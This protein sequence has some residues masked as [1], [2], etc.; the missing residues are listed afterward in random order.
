LESHGDGLELEFSSSWGDGRLESP[1]LGDF[2]ADNLLLAL[3][4]LLAWGMPVA[5]AMRRLRNVTAVTGRM[6]SLGGDERPR[7]VVDYA[8]TPDALE[9]S[10]LA[11]RPHTTGRL[12]LVFG[13]GGDR[14]AGKRPLM[15]AI[16]ER[17]ADRVILTDDNPRYESG[18]AIV[19]QIL[20]GFGDAG[21][22]LVQRDRARAIAQAIRGSAPGDLVLIA[23]KGHEDYQQIGDLRIPFSDLEQASQAL[24]EGEA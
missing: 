14:D 24:E 19:E 6:S 17:L 10:L 3:G 11:L 20:S 12:V 13:C 2:N 4:V 8:H 22:A 7:V 16:A 5:E 18:Q 1:L 9:K 21:V 23:G 15:G